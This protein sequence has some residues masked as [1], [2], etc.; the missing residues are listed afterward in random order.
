MA[1]A[2]RRAFVCGH[3]IAHSRSPLIH[4][5]WLDAF[6]IDGRYDPVDVAPADFASFV[7]SIRDGRFRGGNVTLPHKE[8]AHALADRHDD[9]ARAIGAVNTF[10]ME[11]GALVGG[12]TDAYGFSANLDDRAPGWDAA[13]GVATVLGAG[14]AARAVLHALQSKGFADIRVVN[15]TIERAKAL[16][17]SFGSGI[18]AHGWETTA[19][20]FPDTA[21]L[22]N[23]TSIGLHGRSE[24]PPDISMLPPHALVTDLVYAPLETPLLAAARILGLKTVDGLGMLLHQ[25]VPGFERWFG[26]RPQVTAALRDRIVDDLAPRA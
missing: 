17:A 16:A 4:R 18:S 8:A 13:P 10:W 9:A 3:P 15:R 22:I 24:A 2:D 1:D 26:V 5:F 7:G 14:G 23:T 25:A 6:R 12:N 21:L 19:N 20:H 11:D